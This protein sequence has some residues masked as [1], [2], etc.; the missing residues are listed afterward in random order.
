MEATI[1]KK[2]TKLIDLHTIFIVDLSNQL[3][4]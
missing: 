3:F 2:S 4:S 1:M